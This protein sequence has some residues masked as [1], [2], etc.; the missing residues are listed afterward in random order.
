[1]DA[2][3][4]TEQLVQFSIVEQAIATN[5]KL[6]DLIA[7]QSGSQLSAAVS[8]IG[9]EVQADG[10]MISLQ[11]GA[12][13]V[14]YGL[15]RNTANTTI[16]IINDLGQTVRVLTGETSAGLHELVWN[17]KDDK[18]ADLP[19]GI[20]GVAVTAVDAK[21]EAVPAA[22]GTS[23]RVTGVESQDGQVYLKLGELLVP[24]DQVF[25]VEETDDITAA[26]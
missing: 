16:S 21:G 5:S 9:H 1:M 15:E 3:Q 14:L 10:E 19:D 7:L 13:T 12:A 4:F 26:G 2:N 22:A 6:D 20:Y 23:G 25:S 11:D 24:L 18:G 8:Y 17:G